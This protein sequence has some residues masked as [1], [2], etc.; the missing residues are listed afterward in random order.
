MSSFW[1]LRIFT[2]SIS[3]AITTPVQAVLKTWPG[4]RPLSAKSLSDGEPA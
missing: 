4:V 2:S 1:P 3:P